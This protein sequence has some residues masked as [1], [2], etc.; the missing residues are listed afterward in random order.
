MLKVTAAETVIERQNFNQPALDKSNENYQIK[1]GML[2]I[3]KLVRHAAE[4]PMIK[5]LFSVV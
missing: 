3:K 5:C 2:Y 1:H 4:K